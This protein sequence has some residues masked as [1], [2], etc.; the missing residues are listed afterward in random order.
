[1][2]VDGPNSD[3]TP[4]VTSYPLITTLDQADVFLSGKEVF[5]VQYLI[6]FAHLTRGYYDFTITPPGGVKVCKLLVTHIGSN[7]PCTRLPSDEPM[8]D[9]NMEITY[10]GGDIQL[11]HDFGQPA[12]LILHVRIV[13]SF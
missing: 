9:D 4:F 1:M 2:A 7:M 13:K 12:Q 10:A 11:A 6:K 5:T 8:A 3:T